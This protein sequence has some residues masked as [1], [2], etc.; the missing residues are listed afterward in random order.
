MP[1]PRGK[2]AEPFQNEVRVYDKVEQ[3]DWP[4]I[5]LAPKAARAR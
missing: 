1:A 5:G 2:T 4:A 3:A